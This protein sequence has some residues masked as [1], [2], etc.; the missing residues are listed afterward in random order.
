MLHQY[1]P[2]QFHGTQSNLISCLPVSLVYDL[3]TVC[4]FEWPRQTSMLKRS[5]ILSQRRRNGFF[6]PVEK[7]SLHNIFPIQTMFRDQLL[8]GNI[9]VKVAVSWRRW[10]MK[11][12]FIPPGSPD[13]KVLFLIGYVSSRLRSHQFEIQTKILSRFTTGMRWV[14]EPLNEDVNIARLEA[15]SAADLQ[16]EQGCM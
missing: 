8:V 2:Q 14:S 11:R 4:L 13:Y 12:W 10:C 3:K 6:W 7:F 9:T 5:R 16:S 15:T 1:E